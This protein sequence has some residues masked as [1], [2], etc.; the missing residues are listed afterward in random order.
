MTVQTLKVNFKI[1]LVYEAGFTLTIMVAS[2][3]SITQLTAASSVVGLPGLGG[4]VD[5][6]NTPIYTIRSPGD[7]LTGAQLQ[8]AAYWQMSTALS[9]TNLPHQPFHMAKASEYFERE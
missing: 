7:S 2:S 9:Q 5:I 1:V 3:S 4:D 6:Y 8:P